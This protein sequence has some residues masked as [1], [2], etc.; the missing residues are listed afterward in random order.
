MTASSSIGQNLQSEIDKQFVHRL[1]LLR[2]DQLLQMLGFDGHKAAETTPADQPSSRRCNSALRMTGLGR[3]RWIPRDQFIAAAKCKIRLVVPTGTQLVKGV[4]TQLIAVVAKAHWRLGSHRADRLPQ[5]SRLTKWGGQHRF[6]SG[7]SSHA[8]GLPRISIH[9]NQLGTLAG[10]K[11]RD[12]G[13]NRWDVVVKIQTSCD[14]LVPLKRIPPEAAEVSKGTKLLLFADCAMGLFQLECIG[15]DRQSR[16]VVIER[17]LPK[18]NP[19]Q[20]SRC[21]QLVGIG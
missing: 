15:I 6:P 18:K 20:D 9:H 14:G 4:F 11:E 17:Q 3:V 10:P 21:D 7:A 1:H 2:W 19:V 8:Q 13:L 5:H 12:V 16:Q